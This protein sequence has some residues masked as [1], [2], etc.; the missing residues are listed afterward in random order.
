MATKNLALKIAIVK[1]GRTQLVIAEAAGISNSK[2]SE[3]VNG[4]WNPSEAEQDAIA[5]AM[6]LSRAELFR[7]SDV[8]A[9]RSA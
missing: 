8:A 7:A 2:F 4:K 1:D 9:Q 6:N 3:I 5:K